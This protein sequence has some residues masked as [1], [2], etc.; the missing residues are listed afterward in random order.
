MV[1]RSSGPMVRWSN[2][3]VT[4]QSKRLSRV[5]ERS[6]GQ[7]VERSKGLMVQRL[8]SRMPQRLNGHPL[9]PGRLCVLSKG[10]RMARR[11]LSLQS[12]PGK[13]STRGNVP[14]GSFMGLHPSRY[15]RLNQSASQ[16][17]SQSA[18]QPRMK[19]TTLFIRV[20]CKFRR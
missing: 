5:V 2:G 15:S 7:M 14:A 12:T 1:Q 4:V 3:G 17:V 18:S 11:S 13:Q 19:Y 6:N 16:P 8:N 10:P 9:N 20:R